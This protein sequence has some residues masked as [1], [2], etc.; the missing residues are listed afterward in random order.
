MLGILAGV[1]TGAVLVM[2][3]SIVGMTKFDEYWLRHGLSMFM[4]AASVWAA[5]LVLV[6]PVPW[7]LLHHC[8][9]RGWPVAV[10]LGLVLTFLVVFG[11][12]T[13]GFGAYVS[14][15]GFS[16]ADNGGPTWV[17]GRLTPH[18]WFEA[19]QFSAMCSAVGTA[20]GLAVW[21][22]AYRREDDQESS[23]KQ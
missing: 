15:I 3:W 18:G 7:L 5:G 9:L 2:L 8:G 23:R 1:I 22:V 20:V 17:D 11:F 4:Y 13:N 19:F 16:A 12:L 14:E 6:A 10:V 21:R